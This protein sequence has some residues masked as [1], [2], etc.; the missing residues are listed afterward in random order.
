[1]EYFELYLKKFLDAG[2]DELH[3]RYVANRLCNAMRKRENFSGLFIKIGRVT[4]GQKASLPGGLYNDEFK[5]R[6]GTKVQ[7]MFYHN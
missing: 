2:I 6:D 7:L 3:A 4:F 5:L 1:M